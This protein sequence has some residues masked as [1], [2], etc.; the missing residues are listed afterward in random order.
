MK[1]FS[2][3]DTGIARLVNQDY[4]YANED[5]IGELPN[6]FIVADGVGGHNAGD[7]A[8]RFCV[9]TFT[10]IIERTEVSQPVGAISQGIL[11]TN[12]R[13]L[14]EADSKPELKGMG[15]TF[16]VATVINNNLY[17]ANIG[18]SRLYLIRNKNIKQ[19]TEDHSFVEEMVRNGEIERDK[20]RFH[21]NKNII[22]RALGAGESVIP[23]YFEVELSPE[24]VV[25]MCSDGL[26][27]MM[28]D[29]DI[30]SV[31]NRYNEDIESA[32]LELVN[33][34]NENGGKDNISVVMLKL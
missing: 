14:T 26:S 11:L 21:P 6:L 34:A 19:I 16:V 8:S 33:K 27:N 17:V 5:G 32:C 25:L 4:V 18:D 13:L 23:D 28:D 7:Y 31:V 29:M 2:I 30:L 9:E 1:S 24:D 10:E 12:E 15:T 20:A 3:T 22:T